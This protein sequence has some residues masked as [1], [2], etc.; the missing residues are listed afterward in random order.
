MATNYT[1][2]NARKKK[3]DEFYTMYQDI[4]KEM[5]YY[6]D[7]FKNKVVYCNCDN[8]KMSAFW[9]FFH[10]NF[11][12]LGLKK[13]VATYIDNNDIS[14]VCTYTGGSDTDIEQY[15]SIPLNGNGDFCSAEC[16]ELLKE[17]DIIVTNPPFSLFR[18]FVETII[19]HK[20]DFLILGNSNAGF[21]KFIFPLFKEN[22][23][24]YGATIHAGDIRFNV[25][26][27]YELT[28][29]NGGFDNGQKFIRVTGIRWFTNLDH[30]RKHQKI[31]LNK[32]YSP[33]KYPK[34]D[35][36]DAINVNKYADIPCDY[37]GVM[38]VP[39]TIFDHFSSEQ[40]EII[41]MSASWCET[42]EMKTLKLDNIKRHE[43]WLNGKGMY[44]RIFVK[45]KH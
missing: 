31:H 39:I 20:K 9:E 33:D 10:K 25:P 1:L 35:N 18:K 2:I 19:S 40:F 12:N 45:L 34:Y 11:S 21:T 6:V 17:S 15:E 28:T 26:N 37:D 44:K 14:Y 4:E 41:G 8:P 27:D 5:A 3:K 32:T 29:K 30:C 16:I 38:G 7:K 42:P 13:L 24:W 43:P 36:Y 23:I 22:K